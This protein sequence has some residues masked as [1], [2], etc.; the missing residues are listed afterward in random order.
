MAISTVDG[1]HYMI[2]RLRVAK[3]ILREEGVL[4]TSH[5]LGGLGQKSTPMTMTS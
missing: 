3:R 5:W 4:L 2:I 1:E